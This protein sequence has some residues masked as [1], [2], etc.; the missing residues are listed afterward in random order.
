MVI[1][2]NLSK[3][4]ICDDSML[5]GKKLKNSLTLYGSFDILEATDG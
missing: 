5:I 4:L 3:I 2:G 1:A